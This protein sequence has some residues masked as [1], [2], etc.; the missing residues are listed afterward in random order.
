MVG[1]DHYKE[2][3]KTELSEESEELREKQAN[4]DEGK[5]K[6]LPRGPP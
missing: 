3:A 2:R 5:A 1:L 6:T 4:P